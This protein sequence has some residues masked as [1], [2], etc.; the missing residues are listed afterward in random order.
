MT[1]D[2][3]CTSARL[4]AMRLGIRCRHSSPDRRDAEDAD[5]DA[6]LSQYFEM[7]PEDVRLEV[8]GPDEFSVVAESLP[9]TDP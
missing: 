5:R 2:E 7:S 9:R 4:A 3:L 6:P 8:A 1:R